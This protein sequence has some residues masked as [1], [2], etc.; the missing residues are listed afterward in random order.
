MVRRSAPF[1]SKCVAKQC[2]RV[3]G[4]IRFCRPARW[5]AFWQAYHTVFGVM[6]RGAVW[7]GPPGN[8]QSVT[9]ACDIYQREVRD[10]PWSEYRAT[11]VI[12]LYRVRCPDCGIKT[13]NCLLYTSDA[14]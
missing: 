2:L 10:L 4:W 14:A 11:V 9:E 3:W 5:A 7:Q 13:E 12:E 1:S 6:G 8:N